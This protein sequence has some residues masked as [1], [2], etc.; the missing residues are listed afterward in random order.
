[1]RQFI[2][3]VD[4]VAW[5]CRM[6]NLEQKV[7]ELAALCAVDFGEPAVNADLGL[8]IYLSWEAGLEV[9]APHAEVT[10]YNRLLHERLE[11]NGEGMWGV[12]FGVEDL[13]VARER[14][15]QLGYTPTPV[16]GESPDSPWAD[17]VSKVRESRATEFLGTWMIF[18]EIAYPEGIVSFLR[19]NENNKG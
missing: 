6:E 8:T 16:V 9:V 3:H 19:H 13:E 10:P 11:R 4:H 12:I 15:R 14:A 17:K 7:A 5:I 18:G 1:M 2:D